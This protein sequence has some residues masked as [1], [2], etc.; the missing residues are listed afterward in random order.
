M[1]VRLLVGHLW[2]RMRSRG[3]GVEG[4]QD[5]LEYVGHMNG[6][7]NKCRINNVWRVNVDSFSI[8]SIDKLRF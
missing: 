3:S 4:G 1:L 2:F 5:R 6:R 7:G 8:H